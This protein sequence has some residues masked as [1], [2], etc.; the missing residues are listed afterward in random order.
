VIAD[1]APTF[2]IQA[3]RG[4]VECSPGT[5]L[6]WDFGYA[7]RF[8]DLDFLQAALVLARVVSKPGPD[9]LCL[10]LGHKAIAA[11]NP[12]PRVRLPEL[13]DAE[14]VMHSEEHLVI[15]TSRAAEFAVGSALFGIPRHICPTVALYAE[16][17]VIRGGRAVE[18]WKVTARDRRLTI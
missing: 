12:H 17:V 2:A 4:D 6:L 11:E 7:D 14:A 15:R 1:G 13:P 10:D 18:R 3:R 16:A 5:C 9:R 8:P